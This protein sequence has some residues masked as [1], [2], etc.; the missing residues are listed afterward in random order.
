MHFCVLHARLS[1][2]SPEFGSA[3]P[4]KMG[5]NWFIP[6]LMKRSVGSSCGTT[7]EE[8]QKVCSALSLKKL[9]YALR[10]SVTHR[11]MGFEVSSLSATA[12][13]SCASEMDAARTALITSSSLSLTWCCERYAETSGSREA[14]SPS[15]GAPE[16]GASACERR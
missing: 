13:T 8:G 1:F 11:K 9:T 3:C 10:T 6:A 2:A 5:L 14:P 16:G 7:G 12:E 15:V 4:R